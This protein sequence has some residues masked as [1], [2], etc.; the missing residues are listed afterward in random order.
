MPITWNADVT[1]T[2]QDETARTWT[3]LVDGIWDIAQSPPTLADRIEVTVHVPELD[4][5]DQ[6]VDFAT[7]AP[8]VGK[9]IATRL[10]VRP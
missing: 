7:A 1:V 5:E 8:A 2:G 6:P 9:K 3:A 10:Q 4:V